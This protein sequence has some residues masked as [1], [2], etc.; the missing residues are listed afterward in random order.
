M[1]ASYNNNNNK[2]KAFNM[3]IGKEVTILH[4]T[5]Q[6]AEPPN[7]QLLLIEYYYKEEIS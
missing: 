1:Q 2:N 6:D 4:Q 3:Q 7:S 5:Y